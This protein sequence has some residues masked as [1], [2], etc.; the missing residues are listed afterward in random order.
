MPQDTRDVPAGPGN[1]VEPKIYKPIQGDGGAA[2]APHEHAGLADITSLR[3]REPSGTSIVPPDHL[4]R[5]DDRQALGGT[6]LDVMR[7]TSSAERGMDHDE[8][9]FVLMA[10]R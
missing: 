9:F 10:D 8:A 2:S 4:C 6:L 7:P 3:V 1:A 5:N